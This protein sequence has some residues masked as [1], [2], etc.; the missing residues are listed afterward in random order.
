L[1]EVAPSPVV[2]LN[3]AVAVA[4]RDG[5]LEGLELLNDLG[6]DSRLARHHLFHAAR[7][8]L[9]RRLDRREEAVAA[10]R[11]ALNLPQNQPERRYLQRRIAELT[12]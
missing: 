4:M 2:A 3:R 6:A 5:P 7:A 11:R 8:E 12:T 10:Y 9:L 1:M